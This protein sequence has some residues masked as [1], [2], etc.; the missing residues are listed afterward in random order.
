MTQ[1]AVI[2]GIQNVSYIL[3]LNFDSDVMV[4][5]LLP[6]W[7]ENILDFQKRDQN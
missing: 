4:S 2:D 3:Y 6:S 5:L 1:L 7:E